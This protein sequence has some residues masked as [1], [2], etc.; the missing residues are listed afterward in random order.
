MA[1]IH[2]KN[3]KDQRRASARQSTRNIQVAPL[4]VDSSVD[5][6]YSKKTQPE[7]KIVVPENLW[8]QTR[9]RD[10][11]EGNMIQIFV[12]G[13]IFANFIVSAIEVQVSNNC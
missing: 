7:A 12:A 10:F 4:P 11:Y 2:S 8:M 6:L 13:L 5:T 1:V 3:Q 9:V